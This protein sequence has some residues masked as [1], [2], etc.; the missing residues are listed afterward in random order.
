MSSSPSRS[1]STVARCVIH[2]CPSTANPIA[3]GLRNP[4][5]TTGL[6]GSLSLVS[7]GAREQPGSRANVDPRNVSNTVNFNHPTMRSPAAQLTRKIARSRWSGLTSSRWLECRARSNQL[8]QEH[9]EIAEENFVRKIS[10]RFASSCNILDRGF[11]CGCGL[12]YAASNEAELSQLASP[13]IKFL[14]HS[15][16]QRVCDHPNSR[17][18]LVVF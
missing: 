14:I 18:L 16:P 1:R 5:P 12:T 4:N 2:G 9:A 15:E 3:R 8:L 13:E 11:G 6:P 17:R 10:A 7:S